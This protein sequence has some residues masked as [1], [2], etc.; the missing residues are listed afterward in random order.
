MIKHIQ[1]IG[2]TATA[3]GASGAAA[4]AV[5]GDSLTIPF[6]A[7]PRILQ[8]WCDYQ[9]N[10]FVQVVYGTAHDTTRGMGRTR[11][12]ASEVTARMVMGLES[13]ITSQETMSITVAG[14]ATAGDIEN[15]CMMLA[16]DEMPG[17]SQN[18]TSWSQVIQRMEKLTTI[19]F[20]I[21][22]TAGGAW[23][24]SEAINADSDLLI[25]NREYAV[26]G[27]EFG[28]ECCAVSIKG[29]DTAGVRL[30]VPGST[31]FS[32]AS[33]QWFALL[34]RAFGD[35]MCIPVINSA[36]RNNTLLEA[37]QDENIADV[38]GSLM[39]ALLS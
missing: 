31:E 12:I 23:N 17:A 2:F 4:S 22:V 1:S 7:N 28:V 21:D 39:L 13:P 36:N 9:A 30:A 15:G 14:S 26:L 37:L 10:G 35:E 29:P 38:T 18:L 16:F 8:M 27:I 32:D 20:T 6:G 34:S 33:G 11:V 19:D 5:A 3:P 25:A 24:G